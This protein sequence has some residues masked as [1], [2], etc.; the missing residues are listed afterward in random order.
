MFF[1]LEF[2]LLSWHK[3]FYVVSHI[4]VKVSYFTGPCD[5]LSWWG[6]SQQTQAIS[7]YA[8]PGSYNYFPTPTLVMP[9]CSTSL[10]Q[11]FIRG[12]IKPPVKLSQKHQ[13]LWDAQV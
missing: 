12:I 13:Q 4:K 6:Q 2:T 7:T 5:P 10:G 8:F 11:S 3:I 9:S 1:N